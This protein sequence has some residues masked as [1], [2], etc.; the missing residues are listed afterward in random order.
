MATVTTGKKFCTVNPLKMNQPIGGALA[1]MG[2]RGAMPLLQPRHLWR[3]L[4]LRNRTELSDLMQRHFTM[5]AR[6]NVNDMKWKKFLHR[7]VCS[8]E[9]FTIC[10]SPVCSECNDYDVCFGEE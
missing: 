4:G 10:A 6:W 5:L 2:I 1:F 7:L 3:D 9:G 8:S